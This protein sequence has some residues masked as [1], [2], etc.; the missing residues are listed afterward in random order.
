M[1]VR[2]GTGLNVRQ[3]TNDWQCSAWLAQEP[4]TERLLELNPQPVPGLAHTKTP[5]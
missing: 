4:I 1:Q 5:A 3:H 2:A